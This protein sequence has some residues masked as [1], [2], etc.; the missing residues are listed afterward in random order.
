MGRRR[1]ALLLTND[2][3]DKQKPVGDTPAHRD[4]HIRM[5]CRIEIRKKR[6]QWNFKIKLSTVI[7][8]RVCWQC[9]IGGEGK[10][11]WWF[12]ALF[13]SH[14]WVAQYAHWCDANHVNWCHKKHLSRGLRVEKSQ[15][16]CGDWI[17]SIYISWND[18]ILTVDSDYFVRFVCRSRHCDVW[19]STE[20]AIWTVRF[21]KRRRSGEHFFFFNNNREL[22][23]VWSICIHSLVDCY[24]VT[25]SFIRKQYSLIGNEP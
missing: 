3:N 13:E 2:D 15:N 18:H 10:K 25:R 1:V 7:F 11:Q 16:V 5:Q 8:I 23:V 9:I 24:F 20:S 17:A 12:I 22:C 14:N 21:T 19:R 6:R 4:T